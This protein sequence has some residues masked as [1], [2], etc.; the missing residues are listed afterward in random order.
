MSRRTAV[1]GFALDYDV[2]RETLH[3]LTEFEAL[4][5]KWNPVINLVS[6]STL[7]AIWDRH[8][9]DSAQVF[10]V[11]GEEF[12]KWVD[13]GSGGGFPGTI[14]AIL[15]REK[16]PDGNFVC[17]ESD[18]RKCEF[19][20]TVGRALD[21]SLTVFSRRIEDTPPQNGDIV[22]AR[23]LAPL[24][25][26]LAYAQRH[27]ATDGSALFLKG[28]SWQQEV[29]DARKSWRFDLEAK[30]SETDPEAALLK[31]RNIAGA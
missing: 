1:D 27:L 22:S 13:L 19:L 6:R 29:D 10:L 7:D 15:A 25:N 14:A 28:K 26:L 3:R 17:I 9:R 23:A 24:S 11:A 2:S 18:I 5:R 30:P 16:V 12:R 8:F 20:R 31:I 4:V 21:L